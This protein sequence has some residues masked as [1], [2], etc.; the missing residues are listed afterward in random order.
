M[1]F[2]IGIIATLLLTSLSLD[3]EAQLLNRLKK[4]AKQAAEQK[5]E[6]KIAEQLQRAAEQA[7]E[8][9][10]NSI[11]GEWEADSSGKM[12]VPFSMN[13]NIETEDRY[14]FE[15]IT[16]MEMR[17]RDKNGKEDP[18][19]YVDMHFN[20]D[21]FYTG[22]KFHS[23]DMEKKEGDLFII[24]DLKN[25]AMLMLIEDEDN[26]FSF[27]YEWDQYLI[28]NDSLS[29][30]ESDWEEIE[31]WEGYEK[32]GSK[33]ILGYSCDGYQSQTDEQ[34]V[35][36]WVSRDNDFGMT[37]LFKAQANAKQMRGKI[38]EDY[39]HG[40]VMEMHTENLKNGDK[41]SM[42]IINI[43]KNANI[44]YSMADYPTMS[45]GNKSTNK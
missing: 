8:R 43:D 5:A 17:A 16:T 28:E 31:E 9:S 2:L 13:S 22:T 25:K 27:G 33:D 40:M 20:D 18:P 1:R 41:I 10:W 6:E 42:K 21:D 37:Q 36:I 19:V 7:V 34:T 26:K 32:I 30:T 3:A 11:F 23:Q 12:R 29:Q 35:E 24:Y 38:P 14:S 4:K 44:S 39:P 45:F 15:T